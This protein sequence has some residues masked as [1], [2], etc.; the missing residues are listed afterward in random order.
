MCAGMTFPAMARLLLLG[1]LGLKKREKEA[2]LQELPP[3]QEAE[4]VAVEEVAK[5]PALGEAAPAVA[6]LA[7]RL[8]TAPKVD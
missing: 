7:I 3:L 5:T 6:L 8:F 4:E 1:L 2:S